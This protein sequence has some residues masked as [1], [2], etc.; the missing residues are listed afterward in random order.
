MEHIKRISTLILALLAWMFS[1][2][3]QCACG[4]ESKGEPL[5]QVQRSARLASDSI[6][7]VRTAPLP[8]NALGGLILPKVELSGVKSLS[9]YAEETDQDF[10]RK[11]ESLVGLLVFHT[12]SR[13]GQDKQTI[14]AGVYVWSGDSWLRISQLVDE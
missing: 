1:I 2:A 10:A 8:L 6:T 14:P 9:P 3:S 11:Q 5:P 12:G 4:Q 7:K 13:D